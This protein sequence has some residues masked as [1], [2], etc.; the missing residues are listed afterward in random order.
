MSSEKPITREFAERLMLNQMEIMDA[1]SRLT[2]YAEPDRAWVR[3][4]LA[5][6]LA[7]SRESI[8]EPHENNS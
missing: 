2:G 7:E 5:A 6:A 8:K 3:M 1:L 4:H